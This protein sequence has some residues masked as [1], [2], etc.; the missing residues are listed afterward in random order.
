[1]PSRF[2]TILQAAGGAGHWC[3][4]ILS[5]SLTRLRTSHQ[6]STT[7]VRVNLRLPRSQRRVHRCTLDPF[8]VCFSPDSVH[9]IS[10][11]VILFVCVPLLRTAVYV[12]HKALESGLQGT[13]ICFEGW[14]CWACDGLPK[15]ALG[16]LGGRIAINLQYHMLR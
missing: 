8:C 10:S 13:M 3:V 11:S 4:Y 15:A 16:F 14:D 12:S 7:K 1:M 5:S 9:S 6:V 2:L